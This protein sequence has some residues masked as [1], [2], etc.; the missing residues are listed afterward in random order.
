M[1]ETLQNELRRILEDHITLY[2]ETYYLEDIEE[3]LEG[4]DKVLY[5]QEEIHLM[6]IDNL[7][8]VEDEKGRGR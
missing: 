5:T 1:N 3:I 8:Y 7:E 6:M 2:E 4:F